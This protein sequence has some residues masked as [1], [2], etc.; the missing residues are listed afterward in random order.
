MQLDSPGEYS[1]IVIYAGDG[2]VVA[3]APHRIQ[4]QRATPQ[5]LRRDPLPTSTFSLWQAHH[6]ITAAWVVQTHDAGAPPDTA[7]AAYRSFA[8]TVTAQASDGWVGRPFLDVEFLTL[9]R[10]GPGGAWRVSQVS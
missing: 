2:Q 4:R 8:V 3:G 7:T 9:S 5:R 10:P 1:H 6:A